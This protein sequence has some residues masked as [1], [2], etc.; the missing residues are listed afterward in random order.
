MLNVESVEII[1]ELE[2][3]VYR[4]RGGQASNSAATIVTK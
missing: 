4:K 1:V 2:R 3:V